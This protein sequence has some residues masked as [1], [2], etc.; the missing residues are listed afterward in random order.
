MKE[1]QVFISP[2]NRS[3][4]YG[5]GCFE[6]IKLKD[7]HIKLFKYHWYRLIKSLA[8]LKFQIPDYLTE[9]YLEDTIQKLVQKNNHQKLARV[10]VT[11]TR[12]DGGLYDV[13]NHQPNILIQSW[14]LNPYQD[15][16]NE[17]GL[18]MDFF[19]DGRKAI[20]IFSNLKSNNYLLYAMAAIW[21]KEQKLN[22]AII[23]NS[24][25][26]ICDTT[27]ANIWLLKGKEIFTPPLTEACVMGT[28]RN[29][30][31]EKLKENGFTV[32]ETVITKNDLLTAD[33][34]FVTNAIY[35]IKWVK[36]IGNKTYQSNQLPLLYKKFI[37][38]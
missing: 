16:L 18:V 1:N 22:D 15:R 36:Q 30:L 11:I 35:G 38:T 8:I 23:L 10:R 14:T 4:R 33:E 34:V 25:G 27:I 20:D 7:G 6:T 19:E 24:D 29:F 37:V 5:D 21:A 28:M 3:F 32:N 9:P 13:L 26:R 12:G 31:L 17:N 2:D